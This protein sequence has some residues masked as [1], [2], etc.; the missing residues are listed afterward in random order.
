MQLHPMYKRLSYHLFMMYIRSVY[1]V[2]EANEGFYGSTHAHVFVCSLPSRSSTRP[3]VAN[4][5]AVD[6][7]P[8]KSCSRRAV[9]QALTTQPSRLTSIIL[10][11]DVGKYSNAMLITII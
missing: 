11:E 8:S 4:I 6:E 7:E 9:L 2:T 10:A 1:I 3:E 5:Q